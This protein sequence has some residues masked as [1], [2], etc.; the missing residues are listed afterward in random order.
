MKD[1]HCQAI[2]EIAAE[3]GGIAA[4]M[5]GPALPGARVDR[6]AEAI[7][8]LRANLGSGAIGEFGRRPRLFQKI[9]RND[10]SG[11]QRLAPDD[12]IVEAGAK[13]ARG[14]DIMRKRQ[15]ALADA[16]VVLALVIDCTVPLRTGKEGIAHAQRT[17]DA[18]RQ[19]ILEG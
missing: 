3:G 9:G 15:V 13:A 5:A 10:L 11:I 18:L 16:P 14:V 17:E 8:G 7:A 6:P 1:N 2:F 4:R 12:Q 19:E